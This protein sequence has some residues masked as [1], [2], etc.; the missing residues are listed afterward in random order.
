MKK[1]ILPLFLLFTFLILLILFNCVTQPTDEPIDQPIDPNIEFLNSFTSNSI[2]FHSN[3]L[4]QE[5][6]LNSNQTISNIHFKNNS[7]IN[8]YSNGLIQNGT[9]NS[10]QNH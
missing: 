10:N 5:G 3:G 8:F 4:I 2:T 6:R 7:W 1:V 9:L